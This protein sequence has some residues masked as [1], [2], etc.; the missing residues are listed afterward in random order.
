[1]RAIENA[2]VL[3]RS[4]SA[5]ERAL[6]ALSVLALFAVLAV[7]AATAIPVVLGSVALLLA[8]GLVLYWRWFHLRAPGRRPHTK[9]EERIAFLGPVALAIPALGLL[10]NNPVALPGALAAAAVPT[11]VLVGYLVLRWR[12]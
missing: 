11:A 6:G 4:A 7:A 3:T 5:G 2:P 8:L 12:R 9:S 10:W 1:M